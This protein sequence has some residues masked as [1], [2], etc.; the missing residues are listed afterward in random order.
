MTRGG[1]GSRKSR[2]ERPRKSPARVATRREEE[3]RVVFTLEF[4][5]ALEESTADRSSPGPGGGGGLAKAKLG[6]L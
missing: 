2:I 6:T 5:G 4:P 1:A 3:V